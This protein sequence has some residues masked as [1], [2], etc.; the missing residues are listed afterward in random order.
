LRTLS[1]NIGKN[2]E[3]NYY[4][5]YD[6]ESVS[7]E[8][9]G[10]M[11]AHL[12]ELSKKHKKNDKLGSFEIDFADEFEY[13]DPVDGSVSA[14]QGMRFVFTDGSRFVVRLSGTGSVGATVRLY[15]EKYEPTKIDLDNTEA[16]KSLSQTALETLNLKEYIGTDEPTVIT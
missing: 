16:L 5:R 12:L 15:L 2:T 8:G 3:E 10:K 1:R 4:C 11:M 13:K 7:A 6:Y 9:A 14:Q